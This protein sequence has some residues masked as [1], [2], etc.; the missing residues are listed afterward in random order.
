MKN[1]FV[2]YTTVFSFMMHILYSVLWCI[3]CHL[4]FCSS[5]ICQPQNK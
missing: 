1:R 2:L 3:Y 4:A 5:K